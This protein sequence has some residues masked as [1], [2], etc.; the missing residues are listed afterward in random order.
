[1]W[2]SG[3]LRLIGEACDGVTNGKTELTILHTIEHT[4]QT[5]IQ[6]LSSFNTYCSSSLLTCNSSLIAKL[7]WRVPRSRPKPTI[8]ESW[9]GRDSEVATG[10]NHHTW[11]N[12]LEAHRATVSMVVRRLLASSFVCI[13]SMVDGLLRTSIQHSFSQRTLLHSFIAYNDTRLIRWKYRHSVHIRWVLNSWCCPFPHL[14]LPST[15]Q[16]TGYWTTTVVRLQTTRR[17]TVPTKAPV[18]AETSTLINIRLYI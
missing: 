9:S 3:Y 10:N 8:S 14:P 1:M 12:T 11:V 6:G 16:Q 4:R 17:Q 15:I 18:K 5:Q 13:F 7:L 2:F